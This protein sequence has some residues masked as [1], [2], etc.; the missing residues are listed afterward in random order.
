MGRSGMLNDVLRSIVHV[1]LHGRLNKVCACTSRYEVGVSKVKRWVDRLLPMKQFG[2]VV[3]TT[4]RGVMD[5]KE[6]REKWM[7]GQLL[8]FFY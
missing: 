4:S 5:H 7:G 2:Y 3:L 6:A 1:E 8:G